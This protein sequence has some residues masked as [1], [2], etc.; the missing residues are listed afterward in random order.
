MTAV[1]DS[2][3]LARHDVMTLAIVIYI[4]LFSNEIQHLRFA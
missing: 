3:E 2:V 4:V 1:V